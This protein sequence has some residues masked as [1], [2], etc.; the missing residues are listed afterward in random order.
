MVADIYI[1]KD[2][3]SCSLEK[4]SG[5]RIE[6]EKTPAP[7]DIP[8][9]AACPHQSSPQNHYANLEMKADAGDSDTMQMQDHNND[10]HSCWNCADNDDEAEAG[11]A[12]ADLV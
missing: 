7:A 8:A 12:A 4:E 5:G 6:I 9:A 10:N 11:D 3:S 2:T 1:D